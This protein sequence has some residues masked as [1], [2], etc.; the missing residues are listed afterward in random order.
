MCGWEAAQHEKEIHGKEDDMCIPRPVRVQPP[1]A[2]LAKKECEWLDVFM[3]RSFQALLPGA[4]IRVVSKF[5]KTMVSVPTVRRYTRHR[6]QGAA[7]TV[8]VRR[9]TWILSVWVAIGE[10]ASGAGKGC[11]GTVT[12]A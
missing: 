10:S 2:Y 4:L 1:A 5:L 12:D 6:N 7:P 9:D 8:I 11:P 3:E